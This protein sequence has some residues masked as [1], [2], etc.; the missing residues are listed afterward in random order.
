MSSLS[1][2]FLQFLIKTVMNYHFN[3]HKLRNLFF[4]SYV[5][6]G[7]TFSQL[8]FRCLCS[9]GDQVWFY[10][11]V[12]III[13]HLFSSKSVVIFAD[14]ASV[15]GDSDMKND[16]CQ[17]NINDEWFHLHYFAKICLLVIVTVK[18]I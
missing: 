7:I 12:L 18:I 15:I 14:W 3:V 9:H 8:T 4:S 5:S 13:S 17:K 2:Y 6:C 10:E 16:F 1:S 11:Y